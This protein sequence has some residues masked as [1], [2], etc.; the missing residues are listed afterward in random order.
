MKYE[1]NI[2]Q[3]IKRRITMQDICKKY[4][5]E[6]NRRGFICCPFHNE[7]T[8]S[9][10]IYTN[11]N[12]FYCFG[13]GVGGDVINFVMRLDNLDFKTACEK[14]NNDFMLGLPIGKRPNLREYR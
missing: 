10:K 1:Y 4:G 5:F 3:E 14:L 6:I 13:C 11:G 7:K 8:A 12:G 2:S 9:M